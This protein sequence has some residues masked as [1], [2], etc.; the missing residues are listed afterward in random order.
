[1]DDEHLIITVT[2]GVGVVLQILTLIQLVFIEEGVTFN[3]VLGAVALV[4]SLLLSMAI[5]VLREKIIELHRKPLLI[6]LFVLQSTIRPWHI[7]DM[8]WIGEGSSQLIYTICLISAF[9]KVP[10]KLRKLILI[11]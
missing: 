4:T 3:L 7:G 1:M 10:T 9:E 11:L 6:L 8:L 2:C 5:A